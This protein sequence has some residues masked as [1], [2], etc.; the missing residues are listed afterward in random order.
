MNDIN[1]LNDLLQRNL[2]YDVTTGI[3]VSKLVEDELKKENP[4]A[5]LWMSTGNT[6]MFTSVGEY[7]FVSRLR[8]VKVI[9]KVEVVSKI[10]TTRDILT[11]DESY[12]EKILNLINEFDSNLK[13]TLKY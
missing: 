13:L 5:V 10:E 4:K 11:S 1:Y 12:K 8:P 2:Q 7:N 6:L 9:L 3:S